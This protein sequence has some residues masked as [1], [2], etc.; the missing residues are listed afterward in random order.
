MSVLRQQPDL[1]GQVASDATAWRVLATIDE[2]G[3]ARLR[4]ARAA[5]PEAG[6]VAVGRDP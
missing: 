5:A 1:F 3:L 2:P 6:V 4:A